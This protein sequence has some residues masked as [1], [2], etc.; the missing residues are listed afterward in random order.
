M[1]NG[2]KKF[3]DH[4]IEKDFKKPYFNTLRFYDIKR[5]E[6]VRYVFDRVFGDRYEFNTIYD[7][8]GTLTYGFLTYIKLY[9]ENGNIIYQEDSYGINYEKSIFTNWFI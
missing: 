7:N 9:D 2:R 3:L 5:K 1:E 4:I 8:D 6:E